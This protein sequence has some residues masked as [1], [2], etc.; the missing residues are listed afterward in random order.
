[1]RFWAWMRFWL[2]MC[3]TIFTS[4]NGIARSDAFMIAEE[5]GGATMLWGGV[6]LVTSL[7]IA[8]ITL[9]LG[10]LIEAK[11]TLPSNAPAYR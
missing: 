9:R 1:M 11:S 8:A 10:Y 2:K 4:G 5:F 3:F 6:W 7:V